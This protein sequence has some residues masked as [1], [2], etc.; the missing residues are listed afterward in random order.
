MKRTHVCGECGHYETV[1]RYIEVDDPLGA[2]LSDETG[3]CRYPIVAG[4]EVVV[5]PCETYV[6]LEVRGVA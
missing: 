5:C 6:E 1:H 4:A 3:P 2:R